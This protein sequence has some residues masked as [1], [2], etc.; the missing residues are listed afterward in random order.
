MGLRRVLLE[1]M[2][3]WLSA[4]AGIFLWRQ[5]PPVGW[6]ELLMALALAIPLALCLGVSFY[7]NDLYDARIVHSLRS[8]VVR[9]PQAFGVGFLLLA[10]CYAIFSDIRISN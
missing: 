5:P 4:S 7:Y 10:A 1:T 3:L 8:L 9:I 6:P 2:L